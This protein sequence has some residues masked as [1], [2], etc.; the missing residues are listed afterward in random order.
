MHDISACISSSGIVQHRTVLANL[1]EMEA[2][3]SGGSEHKTEDWAQLPAAASRGRCQSGEQE[4]VSVGLLP[5]LKDCLRLSLPMQPP[6]GASGRRLF[7][8]YLATPEALKTPVLNASGPP[9]K[10]VFWWYATSNQ[11]LW[12]TLVNTETHVHP[13][14]PH[15]QVYKLLRYLYGYNV[16]I[17]C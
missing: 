6:P 1:R 7:C 11:N 13:V 2:E 8:G 9:E 5:V 14:C 4:T 3:A 15:T 12:T 17:L 16:K 10:L